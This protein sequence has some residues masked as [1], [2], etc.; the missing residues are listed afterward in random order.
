MMY[1]AWFSC[2]THSQ[3]HI[4][5]LSKLEEPELLGELLTDTY[6]GVPEEDVDTFITTSTVG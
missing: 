2:P 1:V 5:T 4:L 3:Y 6:D